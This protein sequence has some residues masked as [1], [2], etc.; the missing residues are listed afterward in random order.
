[1][2]HYLKQH[3]FKETTCCDF[4]F[5]LVMRCHGVVWLFRCMYG[6]KVSRVMFNLTLISYVFVFK[7][8]FDLYNTYN[9][10]LLT[11]RA[12]SYVV[13]KHNLLNYDIIKL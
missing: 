13:V 10:T 1:M 3:T 2:S 6:R 7:R 11:I 5:T 12:S 9:Y 4:V 8:E